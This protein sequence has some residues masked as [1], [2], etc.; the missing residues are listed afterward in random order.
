MPDV[1]ERHRHNIPF[2]AAWAAIG[3]LVGAAPVFAREAPAHPDRHVP[4]EIEGRQ[5]IYLLMGQSNMSGRGVLEEAPP[6]ALDPDERIRVYGN[7]GVWREAVEPLDSSNGQIDA[8]SADQAG[9]GPGLA[10]AKALVRK[11]G[12]RRVG[13]VPCAK[14]GSAIREWQPATARTTLYG[15]CL[16]RAREAATAG[17]IAGILWYQGETDA[18][19]EASATAWAPHFATMI[20]S[21]RLALGRPDLPL[22]VV[23]LG[24][25]PRTGKYATRFPIWR[26][27]QT[28]QAQLHLPTQAY[29][30]A[31]GLPRNPD[32][33]H[34][35]TASQIRL[36][37]ALAN[38]IETLEAR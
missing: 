8:V 6:G 23:G 10:F 5:D 25:P 21:F 9:V 32:E 35:T 24:D 14:G 18:S 37:A 3:L 26:P 12:W 16:A 15:S 11:D 38:A 19:D 28:A 13:L 29:V 33:L 22:V 2:C 36:G 34:L 1:M 7:D 30:S 4:H 27:V 31:A 20:A 17:R